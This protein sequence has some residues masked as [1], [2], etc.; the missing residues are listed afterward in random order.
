MLR[1][2]EPTQKHLDG[3]SPGLPLGATALAK[4]LVVVVHRLPD[5]LHARGAGIERALAP[6]EQGRVHVPVRAQEGVQ[7][8][9][10]VGQGFVWVGGS[11][12]SPFASQDESNAVCERLRLFPRNQGVQG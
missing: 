12:V 1:V 2:F 11:V 8:R 9:R 4:E 5:S 3:R 6:K 7:E 10:E